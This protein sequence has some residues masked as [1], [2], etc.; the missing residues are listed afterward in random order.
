MK[1]WVVV[2]T[3]VNVPI[4]VPLLAWDHFLVLRLKLHF[5]GRLYCLMGRY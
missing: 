5:L 3:G 4:L 1:F 2:I